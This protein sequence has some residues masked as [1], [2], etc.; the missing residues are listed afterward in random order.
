MNHAQSL[1]I[2]DLPGWPSSFP[3]TFAVNLQFSR[4]LT[5]TV[6]YSKSCLNPLDNPCNPW[7]YLIVCSPIQDTSPPS[8]I[9]YQRGGGP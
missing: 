2:Y 3:I 8:I 9:I 4:N 7:F 5:K 1:S 6:S